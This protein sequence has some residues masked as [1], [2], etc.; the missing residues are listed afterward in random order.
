V[1]DALRK[2]GRRS[3]SPIEGWRD[4]ASADRDEKHQPHRTSNVS[5]AVSTVAVTT[6]SRR[7][8]LEGKSIG[9]VAKNLDRARVRARWRASRF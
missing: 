2:R 7:F 1:I 4:P 5:S 3:E 6:S 9:D 8:R